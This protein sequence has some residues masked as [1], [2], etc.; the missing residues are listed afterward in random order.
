MGK[1]LG[2]V[3]DPVDLVD[4][5]GADRV[6]YFFLKE[7]D[8]GS[9]GDFSEVRFIDTV[10]ADLANDVGNCLNRTLNLLKKNCSG[11]LPLSSADIS[12]EHPVRAA[13][14]AATSAYPGAMDVLNF[15]AAC[16]SALNIAGQCNLH[17]S[18]TEPWKVF[19]GE[20]EADKSRAEETLVAVLEGMRILAILLGPVTPSLAADIYLQLGFAQGTFEGT[21]WAD[22]AWGGLGKGHVTNKPVPLITRL[23]K[24]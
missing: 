9:D 11:Q 7:I 18:E 12:S 24:E 1:S 3:L 16:V 13:A 20:S 14:E 8:F 22:T 6:R 23:E 5:F 4:T 15:N 10:N 21:V 2:N 17:L 19:K